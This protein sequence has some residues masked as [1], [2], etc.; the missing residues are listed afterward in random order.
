MNSGCSPERVGFSHVM[1]K[2][3]DFRVT[4]RASGMFALRLES[5]NRL[6]LFR[7]HLMTISGFTTISTLRQLL[8]KRENITQKRRSRGRRRGHLTESFRMASC[9]RREKFSRARSDFV[10][11]IVRRIEKRIFKVSIIAADCARP[12]G[13][14]H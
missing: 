14:N 12:S 7:S 10:W 6:K 13:K 11:N 8:Q 9:R 3:P 5:P 4:R 1:Y 2:F